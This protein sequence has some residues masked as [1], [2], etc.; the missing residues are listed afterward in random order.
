MS[1]TLP[2]R[3]VHLPPSPGWWPLPLGGWLV[4]A[5]LLVVAAAV[6]WWGY[7]R[8][9]RQRRWQREFDDEVAAAAAGAPRI[10]AIA[11]LLRRAQRQVRP[12]SEALQGMPWLD[13][14][15]PA[16]QLPD[17]QRALLLEGAYR[18]QVDADGSVALQAWARARF[19]AL[20][21][22]ARR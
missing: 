7:R 1:A 10:A 8:R 18:P 22:G 4:L 20:R 9:A 3:D 5:G 12:G 16:R 19:L 17:A 15:D 11:A 6:A 14:I 21:Q 2:L 13:C